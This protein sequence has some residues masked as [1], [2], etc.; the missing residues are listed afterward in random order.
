MID[1]RCLVHSW[2]PGTAFIPFQV[3]LLLVAM[4]EQ[5]PKMYM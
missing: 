4:N 3:L 5:G 1:L 2:E